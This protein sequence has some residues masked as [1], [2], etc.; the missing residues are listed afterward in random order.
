MDTNDDYTKEGI[1]FSHF[2][3]EKKKIM[4][5]FREILENI[6]R[7]VFLD[8][9]KGPVF[10]KELLERL[11]KKVRDLKTEIPSNVNPTDK[12][13]IK[14]IALNLEKATKSTKLKMFFVKNKVI[15]KLKS[16]LEELLK[17]EEK[18][19]LKKVVKDAIIN[20]YE[21]AG[22]NAPGVLSYLEAE[23]DKLYR[24]LEKLYNRISDQRILFENKEKEITKKIRSGYGVILFDKDIEEYKI[25]LEKRYGTDYL[26]ARDKAAVEIL[27]NWKNL[28]DIVL[29]YQENKGWLD[30]DDKKDLPFPDN[31]LEPL[32]NKA[33]EIFIDI[34]KS[35]VF[36]KWKEF[37]STIDERKTIAKELIDKVKYSIEVISHRVEEGGRAPIAKMEILVIPNTPSP[38]RTEF[39][40]E[41]KKSRNYSKNFKEI[42]S[43]YNYRI[44][45]IRELIRWPIRAASGITEPE[46]SLYSDSLKCNDFPTFHTRKDVN[47]IPLNTQELQRIKEIKRTIILGVLFDKI[48]IKHGKL[49]INLKDENFE[50]PLDIDK[51]TFE[52]IKDDKGI[53]KKL[54]K[55]IEYLRED[56]G[57]SKFIQEILDKIKMGKGNEIYNWDGKEIEKLIME[58]ITQ[59]KSLSKELMKI[60]PIDEKTKE[61]LYK[62][63]GDPKP[64]GGE[65]DKDGFYCVDCGGLIGYTEEEALQNKW[66]CVNGHQFYDPFS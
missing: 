7:E 10:L 44:F 64:K 9:E 15:S 5:K 49:V 35:D 18:S 21:F 39:L 50:L 29:K 53:I 16:K 54:Q 45:I 23:L 3:K 37:Y 42:E 32:I 14:N 41:I 66:E 40:D 62:K 28:L 4:N 33:R 19:L 11:L 56:L 51:A 2:L 60:K 48:E 6:I 30:Y 8:Y 47:W 52:I 58:Y 65:Y 55:N 46:N 57:D 20:D 59:D 61:K 13:K 12:D 25:Y 27:K 36:E 22:E 38:M 43:P 31:I 1:V 24:F 63:K 34:V 26:I 17:K